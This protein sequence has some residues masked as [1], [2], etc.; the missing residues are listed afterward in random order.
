MGCMKSLAVRAE[1]GTGKRHKESSFDPRTFYSF[2]LTLRHVTYTRISMCGVE[3]SRRG[4]RSLDF[5]F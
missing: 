2:L 4:D 1:K 3:L 5:S